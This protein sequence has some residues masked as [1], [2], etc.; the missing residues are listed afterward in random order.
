MPPSETT[1]PHRHC[2]G[3]VIVG[4][5]IGRGEAQERGVVGETPNLAARLQAIAEPN[6][7]VI[8]ASTRR[9]LGNSSSITISVPLPPKASTSRCMPSRC[10]VRAASK[11]GL[12]RFIVCPDP[13]RRPRR[14]NRTAAA[15]LGAGKERRRPSGAA[16]GRARHWQVAHRRHYGAAAR[17]T[18]HRLRYFCSPHHQASALYPFISQLEHAAGFERDDAPERKLDKLEALLARAS[19]DV[20]RDAAL[21][22][23]L[24]SIP[25]GGRYQPLDLSPQKRKEETLTAMLAQLEGWRRACR[26][27]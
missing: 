18:E 5:L 8:A 14:G 17:R 9:L 19:R 13:A 11:V 2:T 20:A 26:C 7:V 12:R 23:D 15:S 24:L 6:T 16:I 21:L 10:F 1:G 22:A 25:S 27:S 4:D 3:P